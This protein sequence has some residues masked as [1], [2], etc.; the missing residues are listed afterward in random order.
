M[1]GKPPYFTTKDTKIDGVDVKLLK[2]LAEKMRFQPNIIIPKTF[3]A[4]AH[5]VGVCN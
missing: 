2:L 5:V 1:V 4:V 3:L